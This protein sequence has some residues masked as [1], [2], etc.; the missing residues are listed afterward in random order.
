MSCV[1]R[2]LGVLPTLISAPHCHRQGP[3]SP[4]SSPW[5]AACLSVSRSAFGLSRV[6]PVL[7]LV[8]RAVLETC[9][10]RQLAPARAPALPRLGVGNP[11]KEEQ[12]E[13]AARP[14]G[15]SGSVWVPSRILRLTLGPELK[16]APQP[17]PGTSSRVCPSSRRPGHS[18]W[19]PST[20]FPA[21]HRPQCGAAL[22]SA[23]RPTG[24]TTP[25]SGKQQR[26]APPTRLAQGLRGTTPVRRFTQPPS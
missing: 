14:R 17:G 20:G 1:T 18:P 8:P 6:C 3:R 9:T 15:C 24:H 13:L 7:F 4:S 22:A 23:A 25:S 21:T 5:D 19:C 16:P 26:R 10:R 12:G 2:P 11:V